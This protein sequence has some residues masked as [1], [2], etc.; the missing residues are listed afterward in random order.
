[1]NE[2]ETVPGRDSFQCTIGP[3][4][5]S[6]GWQTTKWRELPACNPTGG[7]DGKLEAHP[8]RVSQARQPHRRPRW[9]HDR[10]GLVRAELTIGG[11]GAAAWG[12][13]VHPAVM[14]FDNLVCRWPSGSGEPR[15][16]GWCCGHGRTTGHPRASAG[17]DV[18]GA[19]FATRRR[20]LDEWKYGD[21]E[22]PIPSDRFSG[23]NR[24]QG[25]RIDHAQACYGFAKTRAREG[26]LE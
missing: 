22:Y 17:L 8:T 4:R 1:M 24:L 6:N 3:V 18:N 16:L 12:P 19:K 10:G 14:I 7:S 25:G 26:I 11:S 9:P 2:P 13:A 5:V 15:R 20:L 23:T 21:Q